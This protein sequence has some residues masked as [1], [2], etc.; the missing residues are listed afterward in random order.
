MQAKF[1]GNMEW[2]DTD[3][4]LPGAIPESLRKARLLWEEN[5]KKNQS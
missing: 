3:D 5:P 2:F 4:E 1:Y